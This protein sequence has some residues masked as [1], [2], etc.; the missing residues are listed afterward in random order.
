M[1]VC[2]SSEGVSVSAWRARVASTREPRAERVIN[3]GSLYSFSAIN[4]H[5]ALPLSHLP[6]THVVI[7][8]S[9]PLSLAFRSSTLAGHSAHNNYQKPAPSIKSM[10]SLP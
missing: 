8:V 6:K 5:D 9:L 1:C 7:P 4:H 10:H 3:R 2:V